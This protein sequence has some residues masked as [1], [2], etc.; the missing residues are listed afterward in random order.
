MEYNSRSN[1][2]MKSGNSAAVTAN[3]ISV[4]FEELKREMGDFMSIFNQWID[5]RRRTLTDD[6]EMYLKTL[7]EERDTA[8]ALKRQ[9][10]QLLSKKQQIFAST[11]ENVLIR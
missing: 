4:H 10:Q 2:P 1:T 5:E 8:E 3:P 9:H 7:R 6:K 11:C